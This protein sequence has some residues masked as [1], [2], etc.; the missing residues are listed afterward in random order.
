MK[1]LLIKS[2]NVQKG[3]LEQVYSIMDIM[4]SRI[5]TPVI[6]NNPLSW[7]KETDLWEYAINSKT[8]FL[9]GG[10]N[11]DKRKRFKIDHDYNLSSI[12]DKKVDSNGSISIDE[13]IYNASEGTEYIVI[14]KGEIDVA[15]S[16]Y[17]IRADKYELLKGKMGD[18]VT[19]WEGLYSK[20]EKREGQIATQMSEIKGKLTIEKKEK[21]RK[22]L[23]GQLDNLNKELGSLS[24]ELDQLLEQAGLFQIG[25]RLKATVVPRHDLWKEMY[26]KKNKATK[27]DYREAS[28]FLKDNYVPDAQERNCFIKAIIKV[29]G[30]HNPVGMESAVVPKDDYQIR[31]MFISSARGRSDVACKPSFINDGYLLKE[32]KKIA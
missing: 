15:K 9:T 32:N 7:K 3:L 6:D 4:F 29:K 16:D 11:E 20:M 12:V 31:P 26:V 18:L 10:R 5:E 24:D 23:N 8:M 30:Q 17:A 19:K 2:D 1:P 14:E 27:Q 21:E 13:D 28:I 25:Y 22:L